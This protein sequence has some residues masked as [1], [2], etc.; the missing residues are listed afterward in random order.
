MRCLAFVAAVLL[1][2]DGAVQAGRTAARALRP[3]G[4]PELDRLLARYEVKDKDFPWELRELKQAEKFATYSLSFPSPV[5]GEIPENNTVWGKFWQPKDGRKK[6]PA[7][8]VLHWLGGGFEPLE[9]I[10]QRLSEGGIA[11]LM[12]YMP[13]YGPRR[14][15]DPALREKLMT[16]EME[17]ALSNVRQA[18]LDARRAGDWL[19]A[20][21]DV[22][23]SR[24][25]IVGIS[26]GA[27]IGS[28]TAGV[29]DRFS[30]SVFIIGGGDLPAIIM[31]GSKETARQKKKL[32][33]AG[34]TVERLRELWKDIEPIT[35]AG[36]VRR[37]DVLMIN[38]E[39]DEI[40]P[41]ASTEKLHAALGKPEIRWFKGGHYAIL[42]HSGPIIKQVVAHL[43]ERP[44][45]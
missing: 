33:E 13:H 28:L 2:Q 5:P 16:L 29:D 32:E 8:L 7:A 4:N 38:A 31:H 17:T 3:S 14:S 36:R 43:N 15:K 40:I 34:L 6:R 10:C 41:R 22:E 23:P 1:L 12:M 18:V 19:A 26:L 27:V 25:G 35:Y 30:R 45:Y 24:V 9:L 21:P 42:F 37:E 39:S 20:R 11:A 44:A